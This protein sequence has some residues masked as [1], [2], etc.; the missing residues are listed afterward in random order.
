MI[1]KGVGLAARP[2]I[3]TLKRGSNRR[4]PSMGRARLYA[5]RLH[6]G[7]AKAKGEDEA[8]DPRGRWT[9]SQQHAYAAKVHLEEA[10][11]WKSQAMKPGASPVEVARARY[12]NKIHA[13]LAEENIN[14]ALDLYK[15]EHARAANRG[16]FDSLKTMGNYIKYLRIH[17]ADD[18]PRD[19]R[20]R[21]TAGEAMEH[22]AMRTRLRAHLAYH[23]ASADAKE[24][25][26]RK[27]T[28][29]T[30]AQRLFVKPEHQDSLDKLAAEVRRHHAHAEA[31]HSHLETGTP[32]LATLKRVLGIA[33][34]ALLRFKKGFR[35][36]PRDPKG[37]WTQHA[38]R[39][40][41]K[42][43][44]DKLR[45][46]Q[47]LVHDNAAGDTGSGEFFRRKFAEMEGPHSGSTPETQ[48]FVLDLARRVISRVKKDLDAGDVHL[49]AALGGNTSALGNAPRRK[50][51]PRL[52]LALN[53][54]GAG[55]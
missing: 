3:I 25:L 38:E 48:K 11:H 53:P 17:K 33:S 32:S 27:L 5:N 43:Y 6:G 55:K 35:D 30:A 31:I 44:L 24:E 41:H 50:R 4:H 15:V 23:T 20:G 14:H 54:Y 47:F 36:Q 12:H 42:A 10:E 22:Q 28:P 34:T 7:Y 16:L 37:R 29:K 51:S 26:L 21:W 2:G 18:E 52:S 49:S 39:G 19:F 9:K 40:A 8:R 1:T 46:L 45:R 13:D